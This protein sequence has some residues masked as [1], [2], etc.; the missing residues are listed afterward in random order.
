MLAREIRGPV[1][2]PDPN[3]QR[4][5]PFPENSISSSSDDD[6]LSQPAEVRRVIAETRAWVERAVVGLNLC[7]FARAPQSKGQIRYV[8]CERAD[9]A[10]LLEC[11]M[12]ELAVLVSADPAHL[13]TTLLM[14]PRG[15]AEFADYN[16]F[17]EVADEMLRQ[18]EL[19]GIIQV[20]SFHPRYQFAGTDREAIGNATNQSPFPTL[21]LLRESSIDRAVAVFPDPE[22]I[23]AA[24]IATLEHLGV[25]GWSELKR[26]CQED[27]SRFLAKPP[28]GKTNT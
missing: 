3:R 15:L 19:E 5:H 23:F 20:A 24:N 22:K 25:A 2:E 21:H 9:Q 1:R 27:A 6:P 14:H 17:L 28:A 11:L 26:Q 18:Q 8:V 4:R 12:E 16:D 13:E 10:G 7:P